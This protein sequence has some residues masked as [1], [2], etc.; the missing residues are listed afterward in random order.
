[1]H[2]VGLAIFESGDQK[3]YRPWFSNLIPTILFKGSS[4]TAVNI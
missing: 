3:I 4:S 1:M 2:Q